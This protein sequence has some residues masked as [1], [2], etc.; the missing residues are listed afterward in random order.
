M[1]T[2][3]VDDYYALLVE[4][5][6]NEIVKVLLQRGKVITVK[7]IWPTKD[8]IGCWARTKGDVREHTIKVFKGRYE[9]YPKIKG[10]LYD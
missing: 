5:T 2:I 8:A 10:V 6:V 4:G 3:K 9:L 1:S 7:T